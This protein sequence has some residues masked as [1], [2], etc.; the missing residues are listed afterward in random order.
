MAFGSKLETS[1]FFFSCS[2]VKSG[3][4]VSVL[5]C[6]MVVVVVVV[7][8]RGWSY[9]VLQLF[10]DASVSELSQGAS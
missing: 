5:G 3:L 4:C 6:A 10:V 2:F 9:K 7:S 8:G 1:N